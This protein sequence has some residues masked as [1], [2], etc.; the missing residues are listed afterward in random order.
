MNNLKLLTV[1]EVADILKV[2]RST[3]Y[4]WAEQKVIPSCKIGGCLRFRTEDIETLI[5][6]C[7]LTDTCYNNAQ[8]RR[9]GKERNEE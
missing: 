4:G 2:K 8:G 5:N 6:D 7:A 9:P 1:T 3:V